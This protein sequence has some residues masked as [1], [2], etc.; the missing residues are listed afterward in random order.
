MEPRIRAG[1]WSQRV[2][3]PEGQGQGQRGPQ[4]A[5]EKTLFEHHLLA[6]GRGIYFIKGPV[7]VP[8]KT[9][10]GTGPIVGATDLRAAGG[11]Q[12]T[13]VDFRHRGRRA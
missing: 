13:C 2:R 11:G 7:L 8:T 9:C 6:Q 12:A 4:K 1:P 10:S 3:G 5:R